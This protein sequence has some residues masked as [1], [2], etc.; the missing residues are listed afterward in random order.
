[1]SCCC[2]MSGRRHESRQ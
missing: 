2:S 1:M